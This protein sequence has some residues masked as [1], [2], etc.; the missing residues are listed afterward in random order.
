MRRCRRR[1]AHCGI[2]FL[3]DPR[4]AGRR[5]LRCPFGCRE[6]HRKG[7]STRRSVAYYQDDPDK[8]RIQN[9][10]R[11]KSTPETSTP[12]PLA[13]DPTPKPRLTAEGLE[14]AHRTAC[15]APDPIPLP[16]LI[17]HYVRQVVSLI[18]GR[19]VGLEEIVE[20]L[21]RAMRQH[22]MVRQRRIDHII[23]WLHEQPP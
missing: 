10:R 4:N 1:C 16:R 12:E 11:S 17:V 3:T 7:E 2:F 6:V 21:T 5:D 15:P 8:K 9:A 13:L 20:M 18:E 23:G 19:P 22:R 14:P